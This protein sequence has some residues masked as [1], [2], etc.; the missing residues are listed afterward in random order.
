MHDLS[1]SHVVWVEGVQKLKNLP[2]VDGPMASDQPLARA[3]ALVIVV[4][5]AAVMTSLLLVT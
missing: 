1:R 5:A 4:V 2:L 3:A